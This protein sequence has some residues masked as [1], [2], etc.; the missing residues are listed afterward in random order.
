MSMV[1]SSYFGGRSVHGPFYQQVWDPF[2]EFNYGST[3]VA[4]RPSFSTESP[5]E[6]AKLDWKETPEAH[7]FKADLSGLNKNEVKVEVEDGRVLCIS[8]EKRMEKEV[9]SETWHR[10][11]R[12]SGLFVRRFR[13]PENAKVDK[14]IAYLENG[15]LTVTAPKEDAKHH[16]KRTIQIHGK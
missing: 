9:K 1:P 15:V 4:P 2:Q 7:V 6:L 5:F 14:L 12:N 16:P 10:V 3:L 11:E 13:L 8:G